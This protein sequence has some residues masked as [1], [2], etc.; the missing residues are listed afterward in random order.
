MPIIVIGLNHKTAPVNIREKIAFSPDELEQGLDEIKSF[1]AERVIVSTCNRTEI[2]LATKSTTDK[3]GQLI[4]WLSRFKQIERDTLVPYLY[5]HTDDDAV[6]HILRVVCGL[7][8]MVLGE[9]QIFGQVKGSHANSLKHNATG[10][11]LNRLM[12]YSFNIAKKVRTQTSIGANPISIAYAAVSLSKQ[13]FTRLEE[14]TTLLV[15]AGETIELVARHLI[16][17]GVHK[18]I[19]ANRSIE[20][21]QKLAN[22]FSG[23]AI[24]LEEI[25]ENLA[26]ADIVISSTAAPIPIIGKGSVEKALKKRKHQPIFMVDIAVPRDIE[27][28]V[29]SLEDVYLYT[30]DDLQ[31][32][33]EENMKSRQSAADQAESMVAQEVS[34]Y[35]DWLGAQEQIGLIK[36]Y[37][38]NADLIRQETLAKAVRFLKNGKSPEETLTFLAHTLTNKLSHNATAA[39]NQAAHSGNTE[40][41]E[42]ACQ[43]LNLRKK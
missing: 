43:L 26:S 30:V 18:I 4:S 29:S 37:R 1:V 33:I 21:A 22:E 31:S 17:N 23:K 25:S 9:P 34:S 15:G 12:Q 5:I 36:L 28:E 38:D 16:S 11:M 3:V 19:V 32:V 24:R 7:D 39:M 2:Y 20:N 35:M 40:L 14:Q 41:L 42:A 13:I 27:P 8:S 6:K 10:L